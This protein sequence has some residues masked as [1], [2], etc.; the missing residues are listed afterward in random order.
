MHLLRDKHALTGRINRPLVNF[1]GL[2]RLKL[3][4]RLLAVVRSQPP[5]PASEQT[6]TRS[7]ARIVALLLSDLYLAKQLLVRLDADDLAQLTAWFHDLKL[8]FI[9]FSISFQKSKS[10][11]TSSSFGIKTCLPSNPKTFPKTWLNFE[12]YLLCVNLF[13]NLAW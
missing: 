9:K 8:L 11:A 12:M 4:H 7:P 13:A 1:C 10:L 5:L 2:F 6:A 3:V